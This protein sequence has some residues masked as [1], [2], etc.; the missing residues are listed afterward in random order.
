MGTQIHLQENKTRFLEYYVSD[1]VQMILT[2]GVLLIPVIAVAFIRIGW[3]RHRLLSSIL[4]IFLMLAGSMLILYANFASA[5]GGGAGHIGKTLLT[6]WIPIC[7]WVV[8]CLFC[9][10]QRVA[11]KGG[12]NASNTEG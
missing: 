11:Q 3:L 8:A 10:W 4:I 6:G 12:R 9:L 2:I 1:W 5:T 7:L